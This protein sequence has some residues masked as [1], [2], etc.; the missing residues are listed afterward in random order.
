MKTISL[1]LVLSVALFATGCGGMFKGKKAAEQ[2]V[3]DFH[4]LYNDGKLTEIYSAGHSKFKGA[5][6]EMQFMEFIGAVQ[7]KLG[8]VTQT[9]NAGFNVRT[10]NLTTTI[11]L[12]QNTT[13]EQGTGTEVFTFEMDG[14]RP[15]WSVT[16]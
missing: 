12:N 7:R 5:T 16:T 2:G 6:T 10:F 13:F 8:K 3:A 14:T 9:S 11:V 4:K 1:F 15:C